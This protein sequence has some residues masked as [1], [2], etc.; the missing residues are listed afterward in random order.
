M[1]LGLGGFG[2]KGL[3]TGLVDWLQICH[4]ADILVKCVS[5]GKFDVLVC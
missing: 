4:L 3:G 1:R 2:T 5:V